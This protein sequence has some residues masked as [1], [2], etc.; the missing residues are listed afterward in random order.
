MTPPHVHFEE[1]GLS[2]AAAAMSMNPTPT[3]PTINPTTTST[4]NIKPLTIGV[5]GGSFNPIHLGHALL[6]IT[7]QQT[8]PVDAVVL[9]PVYKHAVKT[10]LLPFEDRVEMCR[11]AVAP[12]GTNIQVSTIE[13]D[14]G[15]SNGAMLRGLKATCPPGT[16]F[17]HVCG[18]D[19][20]RWM[21][22]PKG[23]ETSDEVDGLIVQRRLHKTQDKQQDDRFFKEPIDEFKI[24]AFCESCHISCLVSVVQ[25]FDR[26]VG[27]RPDHVPLCH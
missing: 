26:L 5:F 22:K 21:E 13:R 3:T 10:D 4:D 23:I 11:L 6:A 7:T 17:Q 16:K 19:F 8:K 12:F 18:D 14:V 9:V 2:S 24:R 15:A 27:N 20:F 25:R 1:N